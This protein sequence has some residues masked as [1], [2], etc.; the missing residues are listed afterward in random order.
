MSSLF[1]V[2]LVWPSLPFNH[3]VPT[4][5]R[6]FVLMGSI[7]CLKTEEVGQLTLHQIGLI[8]HLFV[9]GQGMYIL[10]PMCHL[11]VSQVTAS[12]EPQEYHVAGAKEGAFHRWLR[13]SLVWDVN[14]LISTTCQ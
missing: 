10:V 5:V 8:R 4:V 9:L 7:Q 6:I 14:E 13:K 12:E 2:A 11:L 1:S 3:L